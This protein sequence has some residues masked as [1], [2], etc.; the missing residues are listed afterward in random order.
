MM[1]MSEPLSMMP[2]TETPWIIHFYTSA[3]EALIGK[4]IAVDRYLDDKRQHEASRNEGKHCSLP[5]VQ[6]NSL[7]G[8][9]CSCNPEN[10][11]WLIT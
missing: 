3:T 11:G 2:H 9:I 5:Y 4:S 10:T 1:V 7:F 8:G 6:L